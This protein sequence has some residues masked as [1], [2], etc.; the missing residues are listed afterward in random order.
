MSQNKALFSIE[1]AMRDA[2]DFSARATLT[3]GYL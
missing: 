3:E 2:Q 1:K